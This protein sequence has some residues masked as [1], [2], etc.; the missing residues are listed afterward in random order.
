MRPFRVHLVSRSIGE[1]IHSAGSVVWPVRAFAPVACA[2]VFA[3]GCAH[4]AS[5]HGPLA[6]S[7]HRHMAADRSK[8]NLSRGERLGATRIVTASWYGPGYEGKRTS[9]GE[10]F[11]PERFTAASRR[12]PLDSIVHVTNLRNGRS[13][14]VKVND[15]GPA[16][17]NRALDLSPAAARKIGLTKSGVARVKVS[18]ASNGTD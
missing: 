8:T 5:V 4:T 9:S 12:L 3:V 18:P 7:G 6:W 15:R 17:R 2:V 14:D 10:R 11:D 1:T 16:S 13:V